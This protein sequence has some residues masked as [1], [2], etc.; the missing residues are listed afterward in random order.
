LADYKENFS[1]K[2]TYYFI[3]KNNEKI[4]AYLASELL[5]VSLHIN[6]ITTSPKYRE[7]GLGRS[8]FNEALL[9]AKKLKCQ[10]ITLEI[11]PKTPAYLWY[12]KLG[13]RVEKVLPNYYGEGVEAYFMKRDVY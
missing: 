4:I 5:G 1:K 8:L 3:A 11:E 12:E 2:N 10:K 13:F 6:G 7:L 9:I